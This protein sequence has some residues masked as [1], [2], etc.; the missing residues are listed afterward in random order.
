MLIM[1]LKLDLSL[2]TAQRIHAEYGT[3]TITNI[4]NVIGSNK[5]D[6]IQGTSGSNTLSGG[7]EMII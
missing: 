4:E 3:D 2:T 5:N 6:Y 1:V 7:S